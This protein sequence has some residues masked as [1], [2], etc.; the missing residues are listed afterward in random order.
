MEGNRKQSMRA[1]YLGYDSMRRKADK[2]M[3]GG[4]AKRVQK[5]RM[6]G[7]VADMAVRAINTAQSTRKPL[8]Q[9]KD[10]GY[11]K[12]VQ[13]KDLGGL[14]SA[15]LPLLGNVAGHWLGRAMPSSRKRGG[16]VK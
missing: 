4:H 14:V 5:K 16:K 9:M 8:G 11:A 2:M 10:G 7:N 15:A 3:G 12:G 6:G 1:G 13:K